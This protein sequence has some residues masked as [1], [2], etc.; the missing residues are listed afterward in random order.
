MAEVALQSM[1]ASYC[2]YF[3]NENTRCKRGE[4]CTYIHDSFK[5]T[6]SDDVMKRRLKNFWKELPPDVM[7]F[8]PGLLR[9]RTVAIRAWMRKAGVPHQRKVSQSEVIKESGQVLGYDLIVKV[10]LEGFNEACTMSREVKMIVEGVRQ[11]LHYLM[12]CQVVS[13][14]SS[15]ESLPKVVYHGTNLTNFLSICRDGFM[16]SSGTPFGCIAAILRRML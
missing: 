11:G 10:W 4:K 3:W 9:N 8:G 15:G 12:D 7:N 13:V 6:R 14:T 5:P 16:K 1:K 2:K